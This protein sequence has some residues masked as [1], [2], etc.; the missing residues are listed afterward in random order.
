MKINYIVLLLL[1]TLSITISDSISDI[2]NSNDNSLLPDEYKTYSKEQI[3]REVFYELESS[4]TDLLYGTAIF[5]VK[6]I[7]NEEV[8]LNFSFIKLKNDVKSYEMYKEVNNTYYRDVIIYGEYYNKT[9]ITLEGEKETNEVRDIKDIKQEPYYKIEWE[10]IEKIPANYNGRIK[11]K[12]YFN[13]INFNKNTEIDWVPKITYSKNNV[14]RINK[15]EIERPEWAWWN[16]S[17]A[18]KINLTINSSYIDAELTD[19]PIMVRLNSSRINMSKIQSDCDDLRFTDDSNTELSYEIE[20][21]NVSDEIIAWVKIPTISNTTDT[22]LFLYY[23]NPTATNGENITD[24]WSNNF[25]RVYH[26]ND[27]MSGSSSI[28]VDSTG[29]SNCTEIQDLDTVD[30]VIGKGIEGSGANDYLNCGAFTNP[31]EFA[32]SF[33]SNGATG[34]MPIGGSSGTGTTGAWWFYNSYVTIK[35]QASD[36]GHLQTGAHGYSA[37]TTQFFTV[38]TKKNDYQTVYNNAILTAGDYSSAGTMHQNPYTLYVFSGASVT[39]YDYDGTMD[40]VRIRNSVSTVEWIKADYNSQKDTLLSF[41]SEEV[42]N[43]APNVY[44]NSPA[45]T[46]S[47]NIR[48]QLL[49]YSVYDAENQTVNCT[50]YGDTNTTPTTLLQTNNSLTNS[51]SNLSI[52]YNWTGLA[53]I[54]TTYYWFA[55][56]T[57]GTDTTTSDIYQFDIYN[58]VP[59]INLTYPDNLAILTTDNTYLNFTVYDEENDLVNCSIYGM[60]TTPPTTILQNYTSLT[61]TNTTRD[62]NYLWEDLEN[63]GYYW[64]V[65]CTDGGYNYTSDTRNFLISASTSGTTIINN[66]GGSG[67]NSYF[68]YTI[69]LVGIFSLIYI[70]TKKR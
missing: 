42:G 65:F 2:N 63:Q 61:N 52:T 53:N 45:N 62:L 64:N 14:G 35:Q 68:V 19:F 18:N 9:G 20:Y 1:I 59:F 60:N 32:Y 50:L 5:K 4:D 34:D 38:N 67:T 24:V 29:N 43:I 41:G 33:W 44:L 30:F 22:T 69:Y 25:I 12:A 23:N 31:D 26:L 57:D 49:N 46:T 36:T 37:S 16:T 56:C 39:T 15:Y 40:E 13:E 66:V 11:M 6:N 55:N 70:F 21:C 8:D 58:T 10:K 54:N 3:K 51:I 7:W 17:W 47:S 48:F 27:D 28:A